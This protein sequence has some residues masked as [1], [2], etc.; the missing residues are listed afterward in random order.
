MSITLSQKKEYQGLLDLFTGE[1][2]DNISNYV[3]EDAEDIE[4]EEF[5]I[6]VR[7]IRWSRGDKTHKVVISPYGEIRFVE[8][9]T[10]KNLI[11]Q[12]S[13]VVATY[14][15]DALEDSLNNKKW[16]GGSNESN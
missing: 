14:L 11:V 3:L 4:D 5:N 13:N 12:M 7:S 6:M 15:Y 16:K 9:N 2:E 10:P 1:L 8:G